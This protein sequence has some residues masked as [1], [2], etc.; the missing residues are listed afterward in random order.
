VV[1][2]HI[3][4]EFVQNRRYIIIKN[5]KEEKFISELTEAIC[6]GILWTL[7]FSFSFI[8]VS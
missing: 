6:Y 8:Y 4:K 7:T 5:S 3:I 2:I 1:N